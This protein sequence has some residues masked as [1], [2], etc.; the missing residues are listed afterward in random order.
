MPFFLERQITRVLAVE[1]KEIGFGVV[2]VFVEV[3]GN[4]IVRGA[5]AEKAVRVERECMRF[6]AVLGFDLRIVANKKPCPPP[7]STTLRKPEK[8]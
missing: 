6:R 1:I 2:V 4:G 3:E 5:V 7:T 8:S